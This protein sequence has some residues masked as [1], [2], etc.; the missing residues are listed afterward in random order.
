MIHATL[1]SG[2]SRIVLI[3]GGK[4]GILGKRRGTN[5]ITIPRGGGKMR[6]E[7]SP[8]PPTKYAPALYGKGST[9]LVCKD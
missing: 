7:C 4:N 6:C 8:L 1:C 2:V 9:V 3:R 5:C